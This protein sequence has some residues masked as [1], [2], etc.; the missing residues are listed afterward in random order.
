MVE[1]DA[2][3][4][5][6]GPRGREF[7]KA[8]ETLSGIPNSSVHRPADEPA[9]SWPHPIHVVHSGR[10][11][12]LQE[13]GRAAAIVSGGSTDALGH[14]QHARA[15]IAARSGKTRR[16]WTVWATE[17]QCMRRQ[18]YDEPG[19]TR[20]RWGHDEATRPELLPKVVCRMMLSL[21]KQQVSLNVERKGD[22][23]RLDHGP[24]IGADASQNLTLSVFENVYAFTFE[25]PRYSDMEITDLL[26]PEEV[27]RCGDVLSASPQHSRDAYLLKHTADGRHY[28]KCA[29]PSATTPRLSPPGYHSHGVL[30]YPRSLALSAN[31]FELAYESAPSHR[32]LAI[33]TYTLWKFFIVTPR[34]VVGAV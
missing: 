10:R 26:D 34:S 9:L 32:Y 4:E 20:R 5:R 27:N 19:A 3:T 16:G 13:L 22:G 21:L 12:A 25:P 31:I 8:G 24:Y 17:P 29:G 28:D 2:L 7:L 33:T 23:S 15:W 11:R 18:Q 6:G 30:F 1:D 14:T